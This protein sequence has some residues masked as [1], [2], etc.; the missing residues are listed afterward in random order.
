MTASETRVHERGSAGMNS[1]GSNGKSKAKSTSNGMSQGLGWFSIGLGIAEV[2][3][4]GA[5]ARLIGLNNDGKARSVLRTY[6]LREIGAGVALLTK[7]N[8][9]RWMWGRVAGDVLDLSSLASAFGSEDSKKARLTAATLAVT[10]IT[11]LDVICA[12]NLSQSTGQTAEKSTRATRS[13]IVERSPEEAYGFWRNI[14]N[15]PRFM[16]YLKSV[17]VTGDRRSHWIANGPMGSSVAWDAEIVQDEPNRLIA[18]GSVPG[19]TFEN[20][21]TVTFERA[22]GNRGTMVKVSLDFAPNGGTLGSIAG[23]LLG[24]D[25]GRRVEH[26]LRNFKQ[27]LELGEVT[28]SDSSI[29]SGMYPAQPA[30]T[31]QA[32]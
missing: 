32:S 24:A 22:P 30:A 1:P 19:S 16:E 25:I 10:G 23:K 21:G 20:A 2:V 29:H 8:D 28:Q 3:T 27:V 6:G 5:V 18:W 26:D 15:L 9:A 12:T 14:E 17:R 13:I 4:P 7:P 31:R 11:A